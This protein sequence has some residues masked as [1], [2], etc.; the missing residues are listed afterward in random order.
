M[1]MPECYARQARQLGKAAMPG[2]S[3]ASRLC[4]ARL[5]IK[6]GVKGR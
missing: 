5:A 3:Y 2:K 4:Q 6:I 1:Q